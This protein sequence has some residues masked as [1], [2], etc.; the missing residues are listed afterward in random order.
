MNMYLLM[1]G[2]LIG[3]A[4][5]APVG[6]IGVLCI[7]RSLIQGR[8][9]GF[10]SGLGAATADAVYGFIAA[11]G[12]SVI[13]SFLIGQKLILQV[14]GGTFLIFL[15]TR[16]I[17]TAPSDKQAQ[18]KEGNMLRAYVSVFFLTLTNPM[19]ILSFAGIFA[20]LGLSLHSANT[21]PAFLL[22]LGVFVGSAMWWLLLS[23]VA[24]FFQHRLDVSHLKWINRLSG[25]IVIAFGVAALY[26]SIEPKLFGGQ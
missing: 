14:L 18:V 16:M 13:S 2:L 10:I 11:F 20:G 6:P 9:Y 4:I 26:S 25:I 5:A 15:G 7:K 22:V 24:G 1:K 23:T 3:F 8:W 12:L 17:L 19:T 21:V